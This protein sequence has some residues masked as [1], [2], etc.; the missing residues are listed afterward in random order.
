MNVLQARGV[1]LDE[2][3]L[4][5]SPYSRVGSFKIPSSQHNQQK[6]EETSVADG[7]KPFSQNTKNDNLDE[8]YQISQVSLQ[9][10]ESSTACDANAETKNPFSSSP[11]KYVLSYR[12][13]NG[14]QFKDQIV[15]NVKSLEPMHDDQH[16]QGEGII[17]VNRII[18]I[19]DM[20][21][22]FTKPLAEQCISVSQFGPQ[23]IRIN[24]IAIINALHSVVHYWPHLNLNTSSLSIL[25]PF[26]ILY[27]HREALQDYANSK[28]SNAAQKDFKGCERE[29][30]LDTHL[31]LLFD[32]LGSC[33]EVK[34]IDMERERHNRSRPTVTFE[35]LWLLFPPGTDAFYDI[36]GDGILSGFVVGQTSGG[37]LAM[38]RTAP[39]DICLWYLDYDGDHIG[40]RLIN[41]TI[42]PFTGEKEVSTL[43]VIPCDY[44]KRITAGVISDE[45]RLL[46]Q[47][48]VGYG[49][50][51][52]E[53]TKRQYVHHSGE[54]LNISKPWVCRLIY[55]HGS[56]RK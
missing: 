34:K 19:R 3:I 16:T 9:N 49:K 32:F 44:Y 26:A 24:S 6:F 52:L 40:R 56:S 13:S 46:R 36:V 29:K 11:I 22:D 25:E 55:V 20:Q 45:S 54:V 53:L 31:E 28:R 43:S 39:F 50:K 37:G 33:P 10:S 1:P 35:M 38:D 23:Q 18:W 12:E 2:K 42:Q 21:I 4:L 5:N 14:T 17:E 7:A 47:T 41:V 8:N 48:I 30:N 27:H 51:F 15:R